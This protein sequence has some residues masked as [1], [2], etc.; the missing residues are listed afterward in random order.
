MILVKNHVRSSG[1]QGLG[2]FADE[3][4][5]KGT[6]FWEFQPGLDMVFTK[7][8]FTALPAQAQATIRHYGYLD[9]GT[10][11]W[12][13]GF[14]ND[15]FMNH[16]ENPNV[17]DLGGQVIIARDIAAGEEITCDYRVFD[18]DWEWKLQH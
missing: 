13:L 7:E 9:K 2:M 16:S 15:R 6:L 17:T 3:D 4:I 18:A 12:M 10:E 8:E 14:D 5:P 1:I 11:K